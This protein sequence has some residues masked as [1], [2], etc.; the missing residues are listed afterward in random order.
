MTRL[1]Y[2]SIWRTW[3]AREEESLLIRADVMIEIFVKTEP[4]MWTK[5]CARWR[6]RAVI[7]MSRF[8][9]IDGRPDS[10]MVGVC[11]RGKISPIDE[12][13]RRT[14]MIAGENPAPAGRGDSDDGRSPRE[15]SVF[16]AKRATVATRVSPT[17]SARFNRTSE[18]T[19]SE[20]DET[21]N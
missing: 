17:V 8:R 4:G 7:D 13:S 2:S 15:E 10:P 3:F 6:N 21:Q 1:I 14:P 9:S 18:L 5:M 20:T 19:V 16:S 11:G 12:N